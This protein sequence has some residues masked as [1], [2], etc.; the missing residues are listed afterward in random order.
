MFQLSL[1]RLQ[2]LELMCWCVYL[3][4]GSFHNQGRKFST[5][6]RST[7][8]L[9]NETIL[10]V[11]LQ[12]Q[13]GS[14]DQNTDIYNWPNLSCSKDISIPINSIGRGSIFVITSLFIHVTSGCASWSQA[15]KQTC[16]CIIQKKIDYR[17]TWHIEW[18]SSMF[19]LKNRHPNQQ[20]PDGRMTASRKSRANCHSG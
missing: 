12:T 8:Q 4:C 9:Q 2:K 7:S 19:D 17:T 5:F 20:C 18:S 16:L 11:F 13:I 10:I 1:V 3:N 15:K 6:I 14:D